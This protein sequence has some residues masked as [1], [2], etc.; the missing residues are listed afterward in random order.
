MTYIVL[1]VI[2]ID[3]YTRHSILCGPHYFDTTTLFQLLRC[4]GRPFKSCGTPNSVAF[5]DFIN[6]LAILF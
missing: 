6:L 1:E 2:I 3:Y 5:I 4:G